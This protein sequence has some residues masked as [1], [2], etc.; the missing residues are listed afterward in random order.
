[1]VRE[2]PSGPIPIGHDKPKKFAVGGLVV[3][4]GLG[5]TVA[6]GAGAGAGGAGAA[7]TDPVIGQQASVDIRAA[8]T[9]KEKS[10]RTRARLSLH[11][12]KATATE[13]SDSRDCADSATG[14]VRQY[15]AEHPCQALQRGSFAVS[16]DGRDQIVVSVAWVE[17][18]DDNQAAELERVAD[19]PGTGHILPLDK[20][21]TLSGQHYK[22]SVNGN[23]V[24][25][26]E[27]EP[28]AR[29]LPAQALK[30]VA[31]QAAN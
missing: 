20:K 14:Q 2:G 26:A 5:A 1:M 6:L 30:V 31:G 7:A 25:M 9:S 3:A 22:S 4:V 10:D 27:A 29:S 16:P 19:E 17:M 8:R 18:P 23:V 11:N 21:I 24:T 28:D 12:A 13:Q 15:L